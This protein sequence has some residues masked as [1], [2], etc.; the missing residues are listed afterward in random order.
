MTP[1]PFTVVDVEAAYSVARMLSEESNLT[2]ATIHPSA[3]AFSHH[4]P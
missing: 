2:V 3:E 1:Y 4:L